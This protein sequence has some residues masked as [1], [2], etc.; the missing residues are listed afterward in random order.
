MAH[1]LLISLALITSLVDLSRAQ[2]QAPSRIDLATHD[3]SQYR[4]SAVKV[5]IGPQ[6]DGRLDD[7]AWDLAPVASDFTQFSPDYLAPSTERTEVRVLY[8]D[9]NI[10]I[11]AMAFDSD[12]NGVI[13]RETRR[14]AQT[15]NTDDTFD[16]SISPFP[17]MSNVF[18]FINS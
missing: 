9:A 6:I 15:W 4:L 17:D 18:F 10:Y 2:Q 3:Y 8:D 1:R 11:G 7:G 5:E 13:G 14:D 12:P 16:V